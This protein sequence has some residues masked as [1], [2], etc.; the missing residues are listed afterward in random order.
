[1]VNVVNEFFG[2]EEVIGIDMLLYE[3]LKD[4]LECVKVYMKI[5]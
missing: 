3:L 2:I 1:M 4:F 5:L